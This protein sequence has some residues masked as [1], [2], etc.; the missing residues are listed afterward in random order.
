MIEIKKSTKPSFWKR[1]TSKV[2]KIRFMDTGWQP[3]EWVSLDTAIYIKE[4]L[5]YSGYPIEIYQW[6]NDD[7]EIEVHAPRYWSF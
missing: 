7:L 2:Y 1:L 3:D 4:G 5:T 6:V